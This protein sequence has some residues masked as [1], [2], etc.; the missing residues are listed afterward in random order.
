MTRVI[1]L[2]FLTTFPAMNAFAQA[3]SRFNGETCRIVDMVV[4]TGGEVDYVDG[5]KVPG[6]LVTIDYLRE[7]EK[8]SPRNCLLLFVT[9][10]TRIKDIEGFRVIAGKMQYKEFRAYLYDTNRDSVSE[11]RYGE[12]TNAGEVRKGLPWPDD[13]RW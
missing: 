11:I 7:Q 13:P 3:K 8:S 10:A 9:P 12:D 1:I 2:L 6:N 5:K 4:K